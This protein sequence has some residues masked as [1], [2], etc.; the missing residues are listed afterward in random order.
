MNMSGKWTGQYTY[1]E[2]YEYLDIGKSV[3]FYLD[4]TA[5]GIEF[6]GI[7]TDD[8]TKDIFKE[9]GVL[10]GFLENNFISFSKWYPS[11]WE[12]NEDGEK[13]FYEEKASHEICYEGVLID[14]H[15]E[16]E[17]EISN[18]FVDEGGPYTEI[19]GKGTWTMRK[20]D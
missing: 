10:R 17:W 16:G 18:H 3:I 9:S 2:G 8:E 4:I 7:F 6:E 12:I 1:G 20:D 19:N 11:Y 5:N 13:K 15:F 14:D